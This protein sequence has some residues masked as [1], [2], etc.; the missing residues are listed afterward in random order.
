M[1]H[2]KH[3]T[4]AQARFYE[5]LSLNLRYYRN[6]LEMTQVQVADRVDCSPKYISIL[7]TSCFDNPPSLSIL[8]YLAEALEVEPY[9]L[10]KP[11]A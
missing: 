9:K 8:F 11:L 4:P 5:T 3:P 6:R 2:P 7:E 1:G 10:L